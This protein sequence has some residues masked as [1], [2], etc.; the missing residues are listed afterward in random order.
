MEPL[1]APQTFGMLYGFL[2][3]IVLLKAAW[4]TLVVVGKGI[5]IAKI[6]LGF[7]STFKLQ[8]G[9]PEI[10]MGIIPMGASIAAQDDPLAQAQISTRSIKLLC[11]GGSFLLTAGLA[12]LLIGL[13]GA[14]DRFTDIV[15][16]FFPATLSPLN[17][18][19]EVLRA[20]WK[21]L[22]ASP[23][24]GL[25]ACAATF[26]WLDLIALPFTLLHRYQEN[27]EGVWAKFR[28][29]A[30]AL[31]ALLFLPWLI[32]LVKSLI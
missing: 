9:T 24:E 32:A 4:F 23:R 14:F 6:Q 7:A 20:F 1:D 2:W 31:P 21:H 8:R 27:P 19:A 29:Y 30:T 18:G 10:R 26:A 13:P 17:N 3:L 11:E 28:C 16:G 12:A 15:A 5:P 22:A 25:A